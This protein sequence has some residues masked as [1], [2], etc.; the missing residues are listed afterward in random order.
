MK[1]IYLAGGFLET[2]ELIETLGYNI[3]GIFD[4]QIERIPRTYQNRY[5]GPDSIAKT[6]QKEIQEVVIAPDLPAKREELYDYYRRLGFIVPNIIAKE[7]YVSG[8]ANIPFDNGIQIQKGVNISSEVNLSEGVKINVMANVM[9]NCNIGKF[10]T[11]APNAVLLGY[12]NIGHNSYIGANV[13]I[14]PSISIGS[15]VVVGA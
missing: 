3:A 6:L 10:V 5:L 7:I 2:I 1:H 4:T 15:N 9:H 12:V 8:S 11:I 14:L 13:T